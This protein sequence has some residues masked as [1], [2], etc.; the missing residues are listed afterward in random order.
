MA[1][2]LNAQHVNW[3]DNNSNERGAVLA[4]WH[5]DNRIK[6]ITILMGPEV[7]S[8]PAGNSFLDLILLDARVKV[9]NSSNNKFKVHPYDS[10]HKAILLKINIENLNK[11]LYFDSPPPRK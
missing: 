3:G 1:G 2:D 4:E 6:F 5:R 7:A 9:I 8:Y 11:F 10:D